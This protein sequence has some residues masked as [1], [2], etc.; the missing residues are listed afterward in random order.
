M[1]Y[2]INRISFWKDSTVLEWFNL[3][4]NFG[5]FSKLEECIDFYTGHIIIWFD[6][7]ANSVYIMG[8]LM[9]IDYIEGVRAEDVKITA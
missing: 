6:R 2:S 5:V 8:G 1:M 4:P 3:F 9:L 7:E